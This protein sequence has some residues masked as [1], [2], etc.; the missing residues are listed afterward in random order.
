MV[1]PRS[2]VKIRYRDLTAGQRAAL[3][4]PRE[5]TEPPPR[6]Y[7]AVV[8]KQTATVHPDVRL[9]RP[10]VATFEPGTVL[11]QREEPVKLDPPFW[12][13]ADPAPQGTEVYLPDGTTGFIAPDLV[14]PYQP[15]PGQEPPA[16]PKKDDMI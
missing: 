14:E 15:A 6:G 3:D 7:R 5:L 2:D 4:K 9:T 12:V 16:T 1:D 13:F 11:W 8:V 10:A